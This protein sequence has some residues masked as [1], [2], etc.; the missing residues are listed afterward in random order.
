MGRR[1]VLSRSE[2]GPE[3]PDFT[4]KE[5]VNAKVKIAVETAKKIWANMLEM[6]EKMPLTVRILIRTL[7]EAIK[8][9]DTGTN[10]EAKIRKIMVSILIEN[11]IAPALNEPIMNG[12]TEDCV[13]SENYFDISNYIYKTLRNL[14]LGTQVQQYEPVAAHAN[15]FIN[16]AQYG[17]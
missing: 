12:L 9:R 5:A 1:S 17:L 7:S 11:Y 14:L 13:V 15:A 3:T 6:A 10:H 8:S 16:S 4:S 2:M